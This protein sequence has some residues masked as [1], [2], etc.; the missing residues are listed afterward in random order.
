L[1]HCTL[2]PFVSTLSF[3]VLADEVRRGRPVDRRTALDLV[4]AAVLSGRD[5]SAELKRLAEGPGS[6]LGKV[7]L[8]AFARKLRSGG[9]VQAAFFDASWAMRQALDPLRLFDDALVK[10]DPELAKLSHTKLLAGE[11]PAVGAAFREISQLDD[12]N[13]HAAAVKI[14]ARQLRGD[15]PS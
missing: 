11:Y 14:V 3:D 6:E 9:D 12:E 4:R 2:E 10:V 13:P 5:H 8:D 1:I 7:L 15:A